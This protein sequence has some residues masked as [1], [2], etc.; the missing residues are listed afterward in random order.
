MRPRRRS[1]QTQWRNCR[2]STLGTASAPPAPT[3]SGG[4]IA[5]SASDRHTC[6]TRTDGTVACWGSNTNGYG[7]Y[8]GQPWASVETVG[9]EQQVRELMPRLVKAGAEGIIE[10]PLNKLL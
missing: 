10:F 7:T 9:E 6:G 5:V 4:W 1:W 8:Y 3:T 2:C